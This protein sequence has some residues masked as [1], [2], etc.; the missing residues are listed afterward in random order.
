MEIFKILFVP[1]IFFIISILIILLI[2]TFLKSIA[3]KFSFYSSI[4][5]LIILSVL[6]FFG[7]VNTYFNYDYLFT[8]S[9]FINLF[10]IL[11][12]IPTILCLLISENYLQELNLYLLQH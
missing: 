2:S 10:K 5:L 3:F 6:I 9:H 1:E 7:S 4:I 8:S 11:I 12:I